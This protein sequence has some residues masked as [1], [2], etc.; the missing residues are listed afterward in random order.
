MRLSL[1][2]VDAFQTSNNA[3]PKIHP[4]DASLGM[5]GPHRVALLLCGTTSISGDVRP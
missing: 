5:N 1:N 4:A 2:V 3:A